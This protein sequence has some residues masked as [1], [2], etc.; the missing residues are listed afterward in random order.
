MLASSIFT[1]STRFKI[2]WII[3]L[4]SAALFTLGHLSLI[5]VFANE[6][7]LFIGHTAFNLLAFLIILIPFREGKK[8]AWLATWILPVGL[9]LTGAFDAEIAPYYIG[10]A[11]VCALGLLL[12]MRD[13]F[14]KR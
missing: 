13:F 2:G 11:A 3:L 14:P 9:A 6:Q 7:T 10:M 8:W 4:V 1:D 5:F 12:T